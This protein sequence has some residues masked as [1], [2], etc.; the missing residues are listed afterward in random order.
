MKFVQFLGRLGFAAATLCQ[1]AAARADAP[2]RLAPQVTVITHV[3]VVDVRSGKLLPDRNVVIS[4]ERIM[5]VAPS[6]RAIP[7]PR[8]TVV[9]GKGRFLMPGLFD[10]HVHLNRPEAETR[11][12][13]ANGVTLVRDMGGATALRLALRTKAKR[14]DFLGLEMLCVGTILDGKPAYHPWSKACGTPD[15]GRAAVRSLARAGVDQIKV[16]SLLKP[17]VHRAIC[18]EAKRLNLKP[19]GHVP[20]SMTLEAAGTAGQLGVEHLSGYSSLLRALLPDFKAVPGQFDTGIWA[21]YPDVDKTR[22][23]ARLQALAAAGMVQCPTLVLHQGQGRL[24]DARTKALWES[25]ALPDDRKGWNETPPQYAEYGR[26]LQ[27]AFPY[28]QQTVKAM[29]DAGVP[30]I[31]GTDLANPGI[32]AGFAVH[33]EMQLWQEAGLRPAQILRA[34]T[35]T[36]AGFFGV[37]ARLGTIEK[38]KTAS[39]LL[40]R[41]NPLDDVRHAS[42]IE[43]VWARGRYFN[44]AA[45][46]RLLAE[47][48]E[49][50]MARS[51]VPDPA[52]PLELSGDVVARGRYNL[53]YE[54]YGDGTEEFLIT[55]DSQGYRFMAVRRQSGFG[56]FPVVHQGA[57]NTD[58]T[59]RNVTLTPRVLLPTQ[60][61]Y[62]LEAGRLRG[63]ATRKAQTIRK[64]DV[65]FPAGTLLRASLLSMDFFWLSGLDLK[66]GE[67][68]SRETFLLSGVG[69]KPEPQRIEITRQAD[70]NIRLGA[71][72][73][74]C[75]HYVLRP[76]NNLDVQVEVWADQRGLPMKQVITEGGAKRSAVLDAPIMP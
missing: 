2:T 43:A 44:R 3:S 45:L 23:R 63:Q 73:V 30:L 76:Q 61:R 11:M 50:V 65:P 38:G 4:G 31:V 74:L 71:A 25:Y 28:L 24:F 29:Q 60:E 67:T 48:R 58:L 14:G 8:A 52:V 7:P 9:E 21:R 18:E 36:P 1:F 34:A 37:A 54:Q 40:T 72:Q 32:V 75:R 5:A 64:T 16:Y 17:D 56:R 35:L 26:S 47:A 42:E 13:V 22:L 70:E 27:S 59:P 12:L 10:S 66:A 41:G 33:T 53:F 19:V 6:A 69:E 20:D 51:S 68:R 57:W 39:F 46:N 55:R 15:E 49:E 62:R